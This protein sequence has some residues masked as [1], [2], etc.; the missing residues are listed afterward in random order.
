V[1][2]ELF[3]YIAAELSKFVN[4]ESDDFK[5]PPGRKRELGFTFSFPV[6]QTSISSGNLIN[7]TKGFKIDDA[8]NPESLL[9]WCFS[10]PVILSPLHFILSFIVVYIGWS[11]CC[12]WIERSNWKTRSWY[13]HNSFGNWSFG[14][15]YIT[16]NDSIFN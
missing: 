13:E 6:K 1:I 7:W 2:Q 3:D 11:G 14:L 16:L 4:E 15:F 10:I 8:V 9:L 12:G 5:V